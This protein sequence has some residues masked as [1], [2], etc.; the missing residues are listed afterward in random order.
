MEDLLTD[1]LILHPLT[2]EEARQVDLAERPEGANWA[3]DYPQPGERVG[4]RMFANACEAGVDPRPFGG[5]EIR[6]PDGTAVGG[7]GFHGGPDEHGAVEVGYGLSPSVRGNGYATEAVRRMI[8]LAREQ[9]V[10]N[11]TGNADLDNPASH[12]VML[13]AGMKLVREDDKLVYFE[14]PLV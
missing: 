8:E 10:K 13:G 4:A 2:P 5:Y 14:L 7:I 6:L 3:A 11:F 9:G 12:K 1:R